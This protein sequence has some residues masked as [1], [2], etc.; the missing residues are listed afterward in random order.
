[1]PLFH[2][3]TASRQLVS[4]VSRIEIYSD[5]IIAIT[6]TLLILELEVPELHGGGG[7]EVWAALKDL[8][9][10][11]ASFAFSF[12]TI[13]VFWVNHHHFYHELD[14]A[15]WRFLWYNNFFLFWMCLVPFT[16]AFLGENPFNPWVAMVYCFVL[17]MGALAFML[18][19]RH[20]LFVGNLVH[21]HIPHER[22][23]AYYRRGWIG[24]VCYGLGTIFAP[25]V[26]LLSIGFMVFVP[27]FYIAPR[28]MHDHDGEMG[29]IDRGGVTS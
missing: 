27:L 13:S 20:A 12:L 26:P 19:S 21:D 23:I 5:A 17:F 10:H 15:D 7:A 25:I 9:P 28:L 8:L 29:E 24:V 14:H 22:R 1:M 11:F 3:H 18:F 6:I 2:K 4:D 16:T